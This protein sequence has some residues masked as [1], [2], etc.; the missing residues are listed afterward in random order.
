MPIT[1]EDR[2]RQNID[3]L[4]TA[5][6]WIVKARGLAISWLGRGI[7]VGECPLKSDH[8]EADYL[9]WVSSQGYKLSCLHRLGRTQTF[10][11]ATGPEVCGCSSSGFGTIRGDWD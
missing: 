6:G 4:L 5:A 11:C 2:A 8:G 7:A 9:L 10:R 1:P 3:K